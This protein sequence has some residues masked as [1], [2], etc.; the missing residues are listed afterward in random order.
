MTIEPIPSTLI[1]RAKEAG[2]KTI[3]LNFS[4]GS[5][6]GYLNVSLNDDAM[7]DGELESAIEEWAW[8]AYTYSGAGDGH[9]YG[10]DITYDLETMQATITDWCMT[11]RDG[12]SFVIDFD[13][14]DDNVS[15]DDCEYSQEALDAL[16]GDSKLKEQSELL[17]SLINWSA[18]HDQFIPLELRKIIQSAQELT[19]DGQ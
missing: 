1:N 12:E 5:D 6:E 7:H 9:D 3:T 16:S 10:D 17:K 18:S 8:E 11:R 13:V 4:G 19:K 14:E 2:V 15:I